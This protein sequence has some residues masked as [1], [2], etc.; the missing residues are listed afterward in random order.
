MQTREQNYL[1]HVITEKKHLLKRNI[2]NNVAAKHE[3]NTLAAVKK[4]T[5]A[6]Q[7]AITHASKGKPMV[8]RYK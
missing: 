7:P 6:H 2:H 8:I 1:R 4:K 5:A 3:W